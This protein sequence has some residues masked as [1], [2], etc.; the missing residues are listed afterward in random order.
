MD[1]A[2][3]KLKGLSLNEIDQWS[4]QVYDVFIRILKRSKFEVE[5]LTAKIHPQF[6]GVNFKHK[7]TSYVM[8]IGPLTFPKSYKMKKVH[9]YVSE[10]D[11][12]FKFI[13]VFR[14][15]KSPSMRQTALVLMK[16]LELKP[17]FDIINS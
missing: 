14:S 11:G 16:K 12:N 4:R 15:D 9:V 17:V 13:T 2:Q 8:T 1:L 6:I 5:N 3:T 7:N 10:T